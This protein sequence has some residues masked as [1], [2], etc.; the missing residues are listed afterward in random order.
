[1]SLGGPHIGV[2]AS[3]N[4]SDTV[5][6]WT[7]L[8]HWWKMTE[9][10]GDVLDSQGEEDGTVTGATQTTSGVVFDGTGDYITV[11]PGNFLSDFTIIARVNPTVGYSD[12]ALIGGSLYSLELGHDS[13]Y[14]LYVSRAGGATSTA[15][16]MTMSTGTVQMIALIRSGTTMRFF[17]EGSFENETFSEVFSG[18][19]NWIGDAQTTFTEFAGTIRD[20]AIFSDAKSD[21]YITAFYN[22][23]SYTSYEDGDP[24]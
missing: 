4:Q 18:N 16:S 17:I 6:T 13:S 12:R 9:T 5:P 8:D 1:M 21:A 7:N 2:I 22:S 23:G 11:Y 14:G 3:S 24:I 10:S 19:V 15:T 20:F